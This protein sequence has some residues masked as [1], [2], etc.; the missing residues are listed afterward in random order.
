MLDL[1]II[2][3]A[4]YRLTIL[5]VD[6][7]APLGLARRLRNLFGAY[8]TACEEQ[9]ATGRITNA[10]CCVDC[11]SVW[12]AVIVVALWVYAPVTVWV[13]AASGGTILLNRWG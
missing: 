11:T 6:E 1:I 10:L 13:L 2:M 8:Q 3:L 9:R 12:A 4:T 7:E 5:A